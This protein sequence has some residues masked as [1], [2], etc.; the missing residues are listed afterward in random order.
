[1]ATSSSIGRQRRFFTRVFTRLALLLLVGMSVVGII[2]WRI[3]QHWLLD[4]MF[5][6]LADSA[7][8]ARMAVQRGWPYASLQSLQEEAGEIRE[9]TGLR[10]T[11]IDRTG[12]VLADSDADP[13]GMENHAGRP[14]VRQALSEGVGRWERVSATVGRPFM[15]VAVPLIQAGETAAV[16]RV[17]APTEDLQR[18]Q[19]AVQLWIVSALAVA[20]LMA[21]V[22]AWVWARALSEP[23][24]RVSA[25]AQRLATGDLE[26]RV[27]VG[28]FDEIGQVAE[29][30]DQMRRKLVAR[31]AEGQQRRQDLEITVGTLE[32]G[33]VAV[34]Q[35]G[36][37]LFANREACRLLGMTSSPAGGPLSEQISDRTLRRHWEE[38]VQSGAAERRRELSLETGDGARTVDVSILHVTEPNTRIAWLVCLRDITEIA[39]SVAMKTD[40]VANASHELRTPVASIRAA[41]DTLKDDGLDLAARQRFLAVIDRN[42]ERLR[43]LTEDLM[44]LN[45]GESA[46]APLRVASFD[47]AELFAAIRAVYSV[48]AQRDRISLSFTSSV[49]RIRTDRRWLEIILKNLVDNAIKFVSPGGRVDVR[50]DRNGDACLFTVADDGCGIP[51]DELDR[52]FERF[53]QVD[54]SRATGA[55]GTGLGLAIV[56]HAVHA[57]RGQVR[58]ESAVGRGTTVFVSLPDLPPAEGYERMNGE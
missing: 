7:H 12:R 44:I 18:Q 50:C 51:S 52:V 20:I 13:A 43:H 21:L 34:N 55:G 6:Q 1:M 19:E 25:L 22:M 33:V 24:Q 16:V 35:G 8:L 46:A 31:M 23:V 42:V 36:V 48:A 58:I 26:T 15:Y 28:G 5:D 30:L 45:R 32:E 54:K 41:V 53:Y 14:E 17:A 27:E 11:V 47:P 40:F 4:S 2:T 49:G 39:R 9:R 37:V 10:L 29:S 3:A 38:A 56:K 57:L